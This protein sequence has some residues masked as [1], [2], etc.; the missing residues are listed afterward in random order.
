MEISGKVKCVIWLGTMLVE[1]MGSPSSV[2]TLQV[3][4]FEA[5]MKKRGARWKRPKYDMRMTT[6]NNGLAFHP[7][8]QWT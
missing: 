7:V 5:R 2:R 4:R 8:W 6:A 3:C 1:N